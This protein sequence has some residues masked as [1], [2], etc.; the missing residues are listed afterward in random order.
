MAD[1]GDEEV[2][3]GEQGFGGHFFQ[4]LQGGGLEAVQVDWLVGVETGE[5]LQQ[6]GLVQSDN[7][8]ILL[9]DE[10]VQEHLKGQT[11]IKFDKPF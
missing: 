9:T 8:H 3:V 2:V 4:G 5:F 7:L 1:Y 10:Y 6:D 11:G